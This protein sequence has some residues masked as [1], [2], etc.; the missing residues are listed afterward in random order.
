MIGSSVARLLAVPEMAPAGGDVF[1]APALAAPAGPGRMFGGE[2]AARALAAAH[3]TVSTDRT[4]HVAQAQ[5]LRPGDPAAPSRIEVTR[6]RDGRR[7][8]GRRVDVEQHGKLIF[9]ATFSFHVGGEAV[10]HQDRIP[11]VPSPEGLENASAWS[12]GSPMWP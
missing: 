5:F 7:F 2:V 3:H 1:I 6:L 9:T 12:D 4:V 11:Q 8:S 10:T